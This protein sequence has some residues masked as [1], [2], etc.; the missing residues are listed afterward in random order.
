MLSQG[1]VLGIDVGCSPTRRSSAVCRLD[2]DEQHVEW[3]IAR[4]RAVE[5]D[6][7]EAIT[8]VAGRMPLA[9]AA[10]D[11]PLRR[12]LDVIGRYRAAER[13][14]T[15]Q[16][17]AFAGKP[18]QAST[19]VGK[20]L[21]EHANLNVAAVLEHCDLA[22]ARHHVAVHEKAVVEAFPSSFLGVMIEAPKAL[23]ARRSDRSDIFFQFLAG[24]EVLQR[25]IAYCL[26]GRLMSQ[27]PSAVTNHDDRAALVCAL[28]ALCVAARDYTAVGDEN[29][30]I[31]LPPSSFVQGWAMDALRANA[32]GERGPALHIETG[33]HG[34]SHVD[35]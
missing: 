22:L 12:G 24:A 29:G 15:R 28:T 11:G 23:N 17:Q 33:E 8:R 13:M 26:P 32:A 25:L 34:S 1:S 18:G 35:A 20:L 2:W 27:H 30:W 9:A 6:R 3:S 7:T 10:F 31:I 21:N 5:P 16:L 4:F 19:P 14:L